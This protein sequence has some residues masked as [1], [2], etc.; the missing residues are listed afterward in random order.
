MADVLRLNEGWHQAFLCIGGNLGDREDFLK[1]SI[2]LIES[3][4][5]VVLSKSDVFESEAW[6]FEHNTPFLNQVLEVKTTLSALCLLD[7]CHKIE[8]TLGRDRYTTA[9]SY[10]ARTADIDILFYD[11]CI[12]TLPPLIVPHP[13]LLER[14]FVLEPLAQIAPELIHPLQCKTI[15]MLKDECNDEG[16]VWLFQNV[17]SPSG[18]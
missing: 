17:V 11:E 9:E 15:K 18:Y 16:R 1:K 5:G 10:S 14:R 13:K 12:Y 2:E 7:V 8:A 6:G 3:E 4:V